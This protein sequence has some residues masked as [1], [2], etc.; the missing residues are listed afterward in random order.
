M[1]K[2]RISFLI[3]LLF[4]FVNAQSN[5]KLESE[6]KPRNILK[7]NLPS[8][9]LATYSF[10]YE[11]FP[12]SY[13]SLGLGYKFTPERKMIF[14]KQVINIVEKS[15]NYGNIN[16]PGRKFFEHFKFE[17]Q[18]LT[19]EMRFYFRKGFGKGA[20]L[21]SFIRFDDYK[22]KTVYSFYGESENFNIDF[23]GNFKSIGL[24]LTFG[25]Q[26]PIGKHLTI[27]TYL[28]PYLSNIKINFNSFSDFELTDNEVVQ[29]AD[30]LNKFKLPDGTTEIELSNSSA[31]GKLTSKFF[32]NLR[33]GVG[34]GYRF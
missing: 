31:N 8:L 11:L 33:I 3:F 30:E 22:F 17:G 1:K 10:Q 19:P 4:Q 24:G 21:G 34:V 5:Q 15:N 29:L 32:P 9:G 16:S 25:A 18:S 27:D 26:Y 2:F 23:V 14:S 12:A 28:A 13:F 7:I 20:F 6:Y